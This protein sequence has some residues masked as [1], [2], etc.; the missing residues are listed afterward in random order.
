MV[1]GLNFV[2]R[3]Y[4]NMNSKKQECYA[5]FVHNDLTRE[6]TWN[7]LFE[8]SNW[9]RKRLENVE[10]GVV[11]I[12]LRGM[13]EMHASFFGCILSGLIPSFMPCTSAKQDSSI[14]WK[15][16]DE[17]LRHIC[18]VAIITTIDVSNEMKEAG[19]DLSKTKI[20]QVEDM[21]PCEYLASPDIRSRDE[22]VLLQHSSGTT[23]LKK[24]VVLT[25]K[26]VAL[27][28]ERYSKN[29]GMSENDSVASWLPLYHDMGLMACM[30]MPA[31]CG[32]PIVQMDPFHWVSK[33]SEF[34][35]IISKHKA[36]FAWM[37]NFAFEHYSNLESIFPEKW[38]LS[39]IKS[40]ISCSEVC[41]S[42]TIRKFVESYQPWGI[43]P[44]SVQACYAMA[45]VVFAVTQSD[46]KHTLNMVRVNPDRLSIGSVVE[47][48]EIGKELVSC[49]KDIPGIETVVMD[50][51]RVMQDEGVVG[52]IGVKGDYVFEGYHRMGDLT[53]SRF[54]GE[55]FLTNDVGFKLNGDLY[56]LGRK[57]DMI[58]IQGRNVY[59]HEVESLLSSI[60]GLKRGRNVVFGV[61][62]ERSGSQGMVVVSEKAPDWAGSERDARD[63]IRSMIESSIGVVPKAIK[64]VDAGWLSKTSSGKISRKENKRKFLREFIS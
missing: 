51:R 24:G 58:I 37:P 18:P 50:H 4:Q 54:E 6:W 2:E 26:S 28:A 42:D 10:R 31:Y 12:F 32:I 64:I 21:A 14:Y 59:A 19:L 13:E 47:M 55:V 53:K 16:H 48:V 44:N 41:K 25:S 52:E 20:I 61:D 38:D 9:I 60:N 35:R 11:L 36:T 45:E 23:G 3:I 33:P 15:S 40:I 30:L 1:E 7:D 34:L 8:H 49:G 63:E 5:S 56:V 17:L 57:D 43:S 62:D 27:H 39:S 46:C 22:E 29:I